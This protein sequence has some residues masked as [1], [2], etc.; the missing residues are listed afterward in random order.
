MSPNQIPC[1]SRGGVRCQPFLDTS[2]RVDWHM[3]SQDEQTMIRLGKIWLTTCPAWERRGAWTVFSVCGLGLAETVCLPSKCL[4]RLSAGLECA[5]GQVTSCVVQVLMFWQHSLMISLDCEVLW[6]QHHFGLSSAQT[7][8]GLIGS[9]NQG[10]AACGE[11][12]WCLDCR[13]KFCY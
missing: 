7:Q 10:F 9:K 1:I 6:E 8:R 12:L 2:E 11:L 4:P 3:L 13:K 5:G